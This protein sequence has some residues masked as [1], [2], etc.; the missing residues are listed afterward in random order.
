MHMV[1]VALVAL[2]AA[3]PRPY[4]PD[5][6]KGAVQYESA[7]LTQSLSQV[8][9]IGSPV[10]VRRTLPVRIS[11]LPDT[12]WHQSGGMHGIKDAVSVKYR[13][14][15][16]KSW[17]GAIPVLNVY[18]HYQPEMGV[19]RVYPDGTR[20]DDVLSYR[21]KV[22]EHRVR[23][24]AEGAWSSSIVFKDEAARP[25]G[26]TGLKQ[27]CASCHNRA[28]RGTYG[29]GLNPGGDTVFSD[30]LDW[31]VVPKFVIAP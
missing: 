30:A 15:N 18:G 22:F 2:L 24:K 25:P 26:Y 16:A 31:S 1:P 10:F 21:G 13:T 12:D 11:D 28:G 29:A 20:F 8:R 27:T 7:K 23:E 17:Y 3:V 14:G 5:L 9:E 6:P 4:V 19:V